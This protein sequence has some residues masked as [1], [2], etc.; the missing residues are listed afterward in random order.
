MSNTFTHYLVPKE[1][2]MLLGLNKFTKVN[3]EKSFIQT[4]A[5]ILYTTHSAI[6]NNT[7]V[8][9]ISIE[10]YKDC[11]NHILNGNV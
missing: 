7:Y 4:K 10:A 6:G 8:N 5:E 3:L 9:G 1:D 2:T 11:A